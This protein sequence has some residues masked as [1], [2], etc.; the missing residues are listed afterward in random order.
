MNCFKAR[1]Q[2]LRMW[3]VGGVWGFS[4]GQ[5]WLLLQE[6]KKLCQGDNVTVSFL[7]ALVQNIAY[8]YIWFLHSV[9]FAAPGTGLSQNSPQNQT[10]QWWGRWH[11][12][13]PWRASEELT[14]LTSLLPDMSSDKHDP[15]LLIQICIYCKH[16]LLVLYLFGSLVSIFSIMF[17][18]HLNILF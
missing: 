6:A 17:Y 18:D 8:L 4:S 7:G 9:G 10:D 13:L 14:E 1:P 16:F 11:S 5:D 12:S 2:S 15:S 3:G